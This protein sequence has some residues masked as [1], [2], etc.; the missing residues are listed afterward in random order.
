MEG[1]SM[2]SRNDII[3]F[4]LL[5]GVSAVEKSQA[6]A[7]VFCATHNITGKIV[8][9]INDMVE[10]DVGF[11]YNIFAKRD[12]VIVVVPASDIPIPEDS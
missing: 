5:Y 1:L 9:I 2:C 6:E 12:H 8:N 3:K 10:A 11:G 4:R 7:V